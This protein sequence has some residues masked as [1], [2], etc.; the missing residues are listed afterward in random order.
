MEAALIAFVNYAAFTLL[1]L[2][3]AGALYM[4]VAALTLRRFFSRPIAHRPRRDGVTL[5]KPLHGVEPRLID[6]LATFLVLDHGGPVQLL[7]GVQRRD[8]PSIAAI[9]ELRARF[10]QARIDLVIDPTP[11]GANRKVSNLINLE[12][13]IAHDAIVLSD[14]DIAVPQ[15]YLS[16]I[17]TTLDQP[18]VGAVTLAYAG[19]GDAGCW[20]RLTAA[21]LSWQFLPGTIVGF[22]FGL[23]RPCMGS[24]IALRRETL[25]AIGGFGAF[26]D[27]LADDYAIGN[28]IA[29]RGMTVAMSRILVTHASAERNFREWWRHEVRWSATVRDLVPLAHAASVVSMPLPLA[30]LAVPLHP[31]LG[32][33]V[34][35]CALIAR[36]WVVAVADRL[37]GDRPA[38]LWLLPLRDCLTLAVF[39]AGMWVRS[40]DWRGSRLRME[41]HGQISAEPETL[42]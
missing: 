41:E 24:T 27:I 6:N 29:A 13:H 33:M 23:A 12:R 17:L 15:D 2:S 36:L 39:I 25:T 20:S 19:R 10:P 35:I 31:G 16:T 42:R 8:D 34:A 5:L 18:N 3:A 7:C 40:V 30:L 14:S 4:V 38:P 26:A 1:G 37:S 11:H 21:G 22:A 28:A 9:E 32:T